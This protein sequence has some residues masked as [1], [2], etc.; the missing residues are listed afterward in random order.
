[1]RLKSLLLWI[2]ILA[3]ALP[4]FAQPSAPDDVIVLNAWRF[5]AGD[6]MSWASPGFDDSNWQA[7]AAPNILNTVDAY[8]Y[9][10]YRTTVTL[11]G[12]LQGRPLAIALPP[13]DEVYE[14]YV[15]GVSVGRFGRWTPIP[16]SP[17]DRNETFDLP[18]GVVNG[19][20]VHIALR[21]WRGRSMTT[22]FPFYTSGTA[23]FDRTPELGLASTVNARTELWISDGIVRNLPWNLCLFSMFVVGCIAFVLFSAQRQR[24]EYLLLGLFCAGSFIDPLAGGLLAADPLVMRRS[25]GPALAMV[26]FGIVQALPLLFLSRVCPRF[27]R[28]LELGAALSLVLSLYGAL[29]MGTNTFSTNYYFSSVFSDIPVPFFLL[30]AAG[31]LMERNVGSAALASALLARQIAYA[32]GNGLAVQLGW[33][34]PRFMPLG[35]FLI[36]IRALG[37][38]LFVVATLILLY[39]RFRDEQVH[40]FAL[41]QEM[42][43]A[44]NVQQYLIPEHL[45]E[46]P[47][48]TIASEY[49][50]AREVGGDFFQVLPQADDS[51]LIVVGDVAGK[52]MEAGMLA[53]LIVGS[54][55]TAAEFT[56][57][58]ARILS[59][60]NKRLQGRGLVTCLALRIEPDGAATLAN[61]GHLPPYLNGQEMNI[62]G[63]LPLG[64]IAGIEFPALHFQLRANDQ[65]MLMTDG[66]A[67]A[68]NA[69]G[70]LFGFDRIGDLLRNGT[71]AAALAAAAQAFGQQDDITVLTVGLVTAGVVA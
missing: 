59:L 31:L 56:T 53:T 46:T 70:Q 18:N 26:G 14:V 5:H 41:A 24:I 57:D 2:W 40:Q 69:Q 11:P 32:L 65:L 17:F 62:E 71:A 52:G 37:D 43:A 6:D 30:A 8:R 51:V 64:A 58:P 60:L 39:L 49:L 22:T 27:R 7:S 4:A 21:R 23:R 9:S 50:P 35:P 36:D 44:R 1:M 15:N 67:E 68:Q 19:T 45:P 42:A 25:L 38:V 33:P 47:G 61:A 3:V 13:I 54:I 55:R 20:S 63:S 12:E 48:L 29:A 34:D 16:A 28:W 10:W 66:I